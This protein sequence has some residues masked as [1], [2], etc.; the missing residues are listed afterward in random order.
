MQV[1]NVEEVMFERGESAQTAL[2]EAIGRKRCS[3]K[4]NL[5]TGN[6]GE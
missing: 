2:V 3:S 4:S 5:N 6:Y 1:S